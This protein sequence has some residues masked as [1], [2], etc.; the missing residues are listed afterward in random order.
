MSVFKQ[1]ADCNIC[2]QQITIYK[3]NHKPQYAKTNTDRR[4]RAFYRDCRHLQD[5]SRFFRL[6]EIVYFNQRKEIKGLEDV[7]LKQIW[8]DTNM[9]VTG[10]G[11]FVPDSHLIYGLWAELSFNINLSLAVW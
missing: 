2:L 9:E 4:R 7:R 11:E 10:R 5:L 3:S 1:M 6:D 8:S